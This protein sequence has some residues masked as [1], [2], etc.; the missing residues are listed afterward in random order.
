[1]VSGG[2]AAG[3]GSTPEHDAIW[4][5]LRF[6]LSP[7]DVEELLAECGNIVT[8][9]TVRV[10]VARFAPLI[11]GRLN[12]RLADS[13]GEIPRLTGAASSRQAGGPATAAQAAE[14]SGHGAGEVVTERL[15]AYGAAVRELGSPLSTPGANARTIGR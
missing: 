4:L 1:V 9:E 10:W 7:R 8:C 11:A 6:T 15:R 14:E 12:R 2:C 13:K 3:A 5:H